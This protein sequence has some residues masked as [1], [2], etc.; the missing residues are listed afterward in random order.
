VLLQARD[1]PSLR[2]ARRMILSVWT[3]H[4]NTNMVWNTDNT[5]LE[6]QWGEAP[7]LVRSTRIAVTMRLPAGQGVQIYPLDAR[8]YRRNP[9]GGVAA[10]GATAFVIDTARDQTVWYEVVTREAASAV[11]YSLGSGGLFQ[12]YTDAAEASA[13]LGWMKLAPTQGTAPLALPLMEYVSR[14]VLSSLVRLPAAEARN[15]WRIPVVR[16][17]SVETAA[18]VLNPGQGP[19]D[20]FMRLWDKSGVPLG[21]PHVESLSGGQTKAFYA[22]ER[23]SLATDFEGSLELA[24]GGGFVAMALRSAK[25]PSG[26][27]CLTPQPAAPQE[28]GGPLYLAQLAA[29]ESYSSELLFLNTRSRAVRVKVE[30]FTPSGEAAAM[31]DGQAQLDFALQPAAL[32]RLILERP[33]QPYFGYARVSAADGEALPSVAGVIR[34]WKAGAV[35][36]EIGAPAAPAL[37]THTLIAPERPWRHTALAIV[38]TGLAAATVELILTDLDRPGWAP[39]ATAILAPGERRS[40]FLFEWFQG[41]P[42]HFN[43]LLRVES[44]QPLGTLCLLGSYNSRG[45]FLLTALTEGD[46]LPESRTSAVPRYLSGAGH[47]T[48]LFLYRPDADA[49]TAAGE[50]RFLDTQGQPIQELFR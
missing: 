31:L 8:G 7:P 32:S 38:N 48:L 33:P 39:R 24:A 29:D 47:R 19:L 30:L 5:S 26:D 50:V 36:S 37:K 40:R 18:A 45:D 25:N 4:Q 14:G 49:T 1:A 13:R 2:E 10:D 23:F 34:V 35:V 28:S 43:A 21:D 11:S 9:L 15:S 20:V 12:L 42:S 46:H 44:A 3:E 22:P 17:A 27:E 6:N 41:L 16:G